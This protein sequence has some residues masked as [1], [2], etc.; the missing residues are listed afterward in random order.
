MKKFA[1]Y[2]FDRVVPSFNQR[3]CANGTSPL[4]LYRTMP[5]A[6]TLVPEW[7]SI[8]VLLNKRST[9]KVHREGVYL[10]KR[11]Y[12]D[13]ALTP[14]LDK[15]IILFDF[16]SYATNCV[17]AMYSDPETGKDTFIGEIPAKEELG[18][19]EKQLVKKA[20]CLSVSHMQERML[21]QKIDAIL[22][23]SEINKFGRLPYIDYDI[24]TRVIT[25]T[26]Y[27]EK[28]AAYVDPEIHTTCVS[29]EALILAAMWQ[30]TNAEIIRQEMLESGFTEDELI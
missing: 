13:I 2:W 22:K 30:K 9:S 27:A 26:I 11:L 16:G 17:Y 23:L 3:K 15:N 7:N 28:A 12:D 5:R 20:R 14:Y 8:A 6:D 24:K 29:K 18:I 4:E 25:K 1:H 21:D 19:E 10:N